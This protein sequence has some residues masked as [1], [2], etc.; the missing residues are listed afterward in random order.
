[1]KELKDFVGRGSGDGWRAGGRAAVQSTGFSHGTPRHTIL[2]LSFTRI[3]PYVIKNFLSCQHFST[4]W[5]LTVH[6]T[7]RGVADFKFSSFY[8]KKKTRLK[9]SCEIRRGDDGCEEKK[10]KW[11][12]VYLWR[13]NYFRLRRLNS[14]PGRCRKRKRADIGHRNWT[15]PLGNLL[16]SKGKKKSKRFI[17][18]IQ[19]K[20]KE[21]KE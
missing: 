4:C 9:F 12:D 16:V 18:M 10:V 15:R 7:L 5:V 3:P 6:C 19:R 21:R 1:M 2:F 17:Q 20:E 13:C 8:S 11:L 14:R